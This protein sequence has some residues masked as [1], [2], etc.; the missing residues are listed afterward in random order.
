MTPT[1]LSRIVLCTLGCATG[2]AQTDLAPGLRVWS[3]AGS[4]RVVIE[5]SGEFS[6]NAD[7]AHNPERL[8]FDVG[9]ARVRAYRRGLP[10]YPVRD[11]L[12]H[13]I[14][15]GEHEPGVA[16]IVFDLAGPADYSASHLTN[17]DRLIIELRPAGTPL[18]PPEIVPEAP[19]ISSARPAAVEPPRRTAATRPA[20]MKLPS[21]PVRP[22]PRPVIYPL[23]P[24][25][26]EPVLLA[27]MA[28][29]T[30]ARQ[31][32]SLAVAPAR[33]ARIGSGDTSLTRVLGL[34]LGRVVIDAGHGGH[35]TGT[36]GPSGF[37]EKDLVL[38]I[39]LRL[40]ALIEQRMGSEIV[41]TRNDDVFIPLEQRTRIANDERADLFI[42]IHANS[43][44]AGS[45]SGVETFYL[46][47]TT[48]KYALEVAARENAASEHTVHDLPALVQL[49]ARNDKIEESRQFAERVQSALYQ[50]SVRGNSSARDRGVKQAPFVVLVGARMPSILCEV[51]FLSNPRD[52]TLLKRAEHRQRLAE[53]LYKG[54][55]GYAATLSHLQIAVR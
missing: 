2:L 44:P 50:F 13:R 54:V 49:I 6:Y 21:M 27:A 53:A 24:I 35:D 51:G 32:G 46:N 37:L 43:S 17:P 14:R 31:R 7:R 41:Y 22:L 10:V 20:R 4:T 42:S 55:S 33:P 34:K 25:V 16:R 26:P 48:N 9:G 30:R 11:A 18:P 45:A 5:T 47:F 36:A 40:G 1:A 19:A 29:P 38:D 15:M 3:S 52:E 28:D 23:P 39:A 8:F 12:V